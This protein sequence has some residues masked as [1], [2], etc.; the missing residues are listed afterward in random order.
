MERNTERREN[1]NEPFTG[2]QRQA[3]MIV[4]AG[5]I[6][7]VLAVS[8]FFF[9]RRS[10]QQTAGTQASITA[11]QETALPLAT[12]APTTDPARNIA[13]WFQGPKAW[14]GRLDWSGEWGK[15][16]Y[17]GGSFG[18]FGCGLC[19]MANIYCS[20]TPYQC[21]PLDMYE[22]AKSQTEYQGGG[23]ID[24]GYIKETMRACGFTGDVWRKPRDYEKFRKQVEAALAVIVVVSSN[25]SECYWKDTPGHYVTL[26][27]Y[28]ADTDRIFLGDSGDPAHNRQWVALKKI[29]KSMKKANNWQYL[30]FTD[31]D[32]SKD[33][34]KNTSF[35]GNCVIPEYWKR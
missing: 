24:W 23:A 21:S 34:W 33:K 6:V 11:V 17:D 30:A 29:Y 25:D 19:C 35:S 1:H 14:K 22:F 16:F 18:G 2:L 28:D 12:P 26:L 3:Y 31:Y 8:I 9:P 27:M 15:T 10:V 5:V 32:K 4:L 13:T 7:L 20:L